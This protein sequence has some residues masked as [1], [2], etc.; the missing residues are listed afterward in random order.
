MTEIKSCPF[1]GN[2]ADY[3]EDNQYSDR[4]VIEC[5]NCAAQ[6]RSAYGYDDVL[7]EWNT[8]Y[9][10]K[11]NLVV[12]AKN[13][14]YRPRVVAHEEGAGTFIIKEASDTFDDPLSAGLAATEMA[15]KFTI[16]TQVIEV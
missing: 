6:K 1:C 16:A 8:R 4:H 10:G 15:K 3:W 12:D 2:K 13:T 5:M 9:D 14:R 11:G 7:S